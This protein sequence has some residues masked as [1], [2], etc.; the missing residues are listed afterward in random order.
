MEAGY[1]ASEAAALSG[2]APVD[3]THTAETITKA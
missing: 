1:T 3:T 2:R